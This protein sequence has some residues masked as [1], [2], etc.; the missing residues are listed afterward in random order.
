M[1]YTALRRTGEPAP[2]GRRL[3]RLAGRLGVLAGTFA[4]PSIAWIGVCIAVTG[5]YYSHETAAYHQFV[6]LPEALRDGAGVFGDAVGHATAETAQQLIEVGWLLTGVLGL[7]V[8]AAV[9]IGVR[10]VP[11]PDPGPSEAGPSEAAGQRAA[12]LTTAVTG[13]VIVLFLF[14]MGFWAYR[15]TYN[16]VPVLLIAVGWVATRVAATSRAAKWSVCLGLGVLTAAWVAFQ[17]FS[18]GPYS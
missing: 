17:L 3:P 13:A 9:V 18:H 14:G 5:S 15:I 1:V 6:W 7:L 16:I 2:G 10:L 4:A 8:A 12:L 11:Q